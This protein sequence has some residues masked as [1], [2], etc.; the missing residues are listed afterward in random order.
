M[1]QAAA[2][3]DGAVTP[4]EAHRTFNPERSK[5]RQRE[6]FSSKHCGGHGDPYPM[7]VAAR[8]AVKAVRGDGFFVPKLDGVVQLLPSS[9]DGVDGTYGCGTTSS[10]SSLASSVPKGGEKSGTKIV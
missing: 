10:P 7:Q 6:I 8:A 5:A 9:S 2:Q 4:L 1:G 3:T